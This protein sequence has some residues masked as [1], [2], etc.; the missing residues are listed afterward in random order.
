[1]GEIEETY[2]REVLV[3][4]ASVATT[5]VCGTPRRVSVRG[6]RRSPLNA[7]S[8]SMVLLFAQVALADGNTSADEDPAGEQVRRPSKLAL[9]SDLSQGSRG[10]L[11]C[12]FFAVGWGGMIGSSLWMRSADDAATEDGRV[13]VTALS[14]G[15]F[16]FSALSAT[17]GTIEVFALVTEAAAEEEPAAALRLG[18]GAVAGGLGIG[19]SGEL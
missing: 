4:G 12:S 19:I 7:I 11:A 8:F 3:E 17:V 18:V 13:A 2:L 10:A 15:A 9:F 5:G 6:V 14:I 1:M 16:T